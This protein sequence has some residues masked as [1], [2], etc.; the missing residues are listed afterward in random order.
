MAGGR[1]LLE[2]RAGVGGM[3]V[4]F[5]ARDLGDDSPAAVKVVVGSAAELDRFAREVA[6]LSQLDHPRVVRYLDHGDAGDARYL[7]M[8]WLEGEDLAHRLTRGR[9]GLSEALAVFR[10]VTEALVVLHARGV[11]HRDIKPSNVFLVGGACE[12]VKLLD[13][14]VARTQEPSWK[15]TGTGQTIG[16]PAYMA[17]EQA[18]GEPINARA[19]LFSLGCLVFECLAGRSPFHAEHPIAAFAKMLVDDAPRLADVGVVVPPALEWLVAA[20]LTK[21]PALRPADATAVLDG[22]EAWSGCIVAAAPQAAITGAEQRVVSVVLTRPAADSN[23]TLLPQESSDLERRVRALAIKHGARL[24]RLPNGSFLAFF[25]GAGAPTDHAARGAA[26]ALALPALIGADTVA[27]AT[28]RGLLSDH[29]PLGAVIDRAVDLLAAG[30]AGVQVEAVT[31]ALLVGRFEVAG[32]GA[33]RQL[34][35]VYDADA[36]RRTLL[37]RATACVGRGRELASLHAGLSSCIED[38]QATAILVTAPPGTGKTR[39]VAEFIRSVHGRDDLACTLIAGCDVMSAGSPFGT[40]GRALR[41]LGRERLCERLPPERADWIFDLLAELSGAD[42]GEVSPKLLRLRADPVLLGDAIADAWR[43]WLEAESQ[44]GAVLLVLEDL[45]WGDLPSLRLIDGALR[46]MSERPIFVLATARPE[47]HELFPRLWV[48]RGAQ[49]LRLGLLNRKTSEQ[50]VRQVLGAEVPDATIAQLVERAGGHPFLLEELIRAA[51]AGDAFDGEVPDTVLGMLQSRFDGL[52]DHTRATL[53]AASVYGASFWAAGVEVLLTAPV[54]EALEQL[55]AAELVER[56]GASKLAGQREYAFRHGLVR[57]AAYA[58]LPA[59]DRATGHRLAGAWLEAAGERDPLVLAGH[60]DRGGEAVSSAR[61]YAAAAADAL[62]GNDLHGAIRLATRALTGAP[63]DATRGALELILADAWYWCGDMNLGLEFATRAAGRHDAGSDAWFNALSAVILS[64]GQQGKNDEVERWLARATAIEVDRASDPHLIC[65][66]RGVSQLAYVSLARAAPYKAVLGRLA[67]ASSPGPLALGWLTRV[68][69][70]T[71]PNYRNLVASAEGFRRARAHFTAAGALRHAC[72]MHIVESRTL[73]HSGYPHEA[74]RELERVRKETERLDVPY[75]ALFYTLE[76]GVAL[77]N[78]ADD[79]ACIEVITRDLPA[80]HGSKRIEALMR[81]AL[82]LALLERG[83]PAA[84]ESHARDVAGS[85]LA[86]AVRCTGLAVLARALD[87]LG[88]TADADLAA[89]RALALLPACQPDVFDDVIVVSLAGLLITRG[90]EPRARVLV[91]RA[92][93]TI[94]ALPL[95][96]AERPVYLRRRVVRD[97]VALARRF[98][99]V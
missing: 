94:T 53:R 74:T 87:R 28:G 80:T 66:C 17:P 52:G 85:S 35:G 62:E 77:Y 50:L 76:V 25:S 41:R 49:E 83:D 43:A 16:T 54:H 70:E 88:R 6:M 57:D 98:G 67:A 78:A 22:L 3:G 11:I 33:R 56:R 90:D 93:A 63:D 79:A 20:L 84:A 30:G 34:L 68:E 32:E 60:Y 89:E 38:S 40:L 95:D 5:L 14:G 8:E 46:V 42:G 51:A 19:D 86:V 75:L 45:H 4:V 82:A 64:A 26:F 39:L 13:L 10:G 71:T 81:L 36:P 58:T 96:E 29:L 37:G 72:L 12:A 21:D 92:W 23:R 69:A 91:A 44:A 2:R 1:F 65:V 48:D 99:L 15:L 47:V 9:L 31:A 59:G 27:L 73:S 97:V 7:A 24:E 61:W 18:R 55:C